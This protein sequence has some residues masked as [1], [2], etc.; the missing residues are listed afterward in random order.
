MTS[1]RP[2]WWNWLESVVVGGDEKLATLR[3]SFT[4]YFLSNLTALRWKSVRLLMVHQHVF[5]GWGFPLFT[6]HF[7]NQDE[8]ISCE[9][10]VWRLVQHLVDVKQ[11]KFSIQSTKSQPTGTITQNRTKSVSRGMH[12]C[13]LFPFYIVEVIHRLCNSFF[14]R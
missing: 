14:L 11:T 4:L 7:V 13:H 8:A 10:V 6:L 2:W 9:E 1:P 5:A 12:I 3:S